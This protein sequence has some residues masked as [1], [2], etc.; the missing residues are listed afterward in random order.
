MKVGFVLECHR[1]GADHQVIRYLVDELRKDIVAHFRFAGSKRELFADCGGMVEKL[2]TAD[3]CDRVFVIWDLIP[4]D[5]E[6]THKGKPCRAKERDSLRK[7]LRRED[8]ERTVMLCITHEL[9]AWLLADGNAVKAE[10]EKPTHPLKPIAD[11]KRPEAI[12][13]PKARLRALFNEHRRRDYDDKVHAL[14]II[15][16][17]K[18]TKLANALS[19]VRFR[20]KLQAL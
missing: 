2:F 6:Y 10:L 4:C 5:D 8:V 15:K 7:M 19:F 18:R 14:R 20:D 1:E 11:E 16:R 13:N 3:R 12:P 9:E 17:A